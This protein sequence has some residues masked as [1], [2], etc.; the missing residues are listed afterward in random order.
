MAASGPVAAAGWNFW[1]FD[2]RTSRRPLLIAGAQVMYAMNQS[3]AKA[4]VKVHSNMDAE[5][6]TGGSLT[7][8]I[9]LKRGSVDVAAMSRELKASEDESGMKSY[10]VARNGVGIVVGPGVK[11]ASLNAHQVRAILAGRIVN[12]AQVGGPHAAIQVISRTRGSTAR[13]FVE[14]VILGGGDIASNAI[15]MDSARKLTQ[16]VAGTPHAIGFISLK[17]KRTAVPVSY[18]SVDGV[19]A[20]RATLLSGRYPYTQSL[21]LVTLSDPQSTAA[22]FVDFV[23]S[24][25]GQ[26]LVD[27][28]H[29]VGTY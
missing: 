1:P 19:E 24:A 2:R 13:Q 20:S 4:F 5:V 26:E 27:A 29:L 6:E 23:C 22:L 14:D 11:F 17:D 10:L 12:W 7:A 8:L 25:Q 9:A 18:L 28:A 16:S 21:Y 3:L 15:E